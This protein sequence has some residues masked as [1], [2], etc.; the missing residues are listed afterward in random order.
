MLLLSCGLRP[1]WS[2]SRHNS[3]CCNTAVVAQANDERSRDDDHLIPWDQELGREFDLNT[4]FILRKIQEQD[5]VITSASITH[6]PVAEYGWK[7]AATCL[8]SSRVVNKRGRCSQRKS[9]KVD[10]SLTK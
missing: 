1:A 3:C 9:T 10:I 6:L 5:P 2:R 7:A 4:D 8:V